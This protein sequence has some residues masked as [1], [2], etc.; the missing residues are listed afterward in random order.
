[1]TQNVVPNGDAKNHAA[2]NV[3]LCDLLPAEARARVFQAFFR[4]KP[5]QRA[6][7]VANS[8]EV[9]RELLRWVDETGHR[10]IR[11]NKA[12]DNGRTLVTL[13][14]VKMEARR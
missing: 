2:P 12:E 7:V 5:G 14:L 6:V 8:A 13:E 1:M 11:H 3:D 10:L 4:V 9:E